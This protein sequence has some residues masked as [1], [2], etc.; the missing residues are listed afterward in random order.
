[1]QPVRETF[2]KQG[3]IAGPAKEIEFA[4][5]AENITLEIQDLETETDIGEGWTIKPLTAH[6]VRMCR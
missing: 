4:A 2:E 1:M 3:A 6:A 5:N